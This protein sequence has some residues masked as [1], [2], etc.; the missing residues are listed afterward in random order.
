MAAENFTADDLAHCTPVPDAPLK[1]PLYYLSPAQSEIVRKKGL[2]AAVEAAGGLTQRADGNLGCYLFHRDVAAAL[3]FNLDGIEMAKERFGAYVW[4][5]E[6]ENVHSTWNFREPGFDFAGL[7]FSGPEQLFQLHK[8]GPPTSE[9]FQVHA[10]AFA[11]ATAEMAFALGREVRPFPEGWDDMRDDV[12][13]AVLRAK[14]AH[15]GLRHLLLTTYPHPLVSVKPDRYWGAGIDGQGRNRLG[16]LLV[17]LRDELHGGGH[18][19]PSSQTVCAV[20]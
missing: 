3:G 11:G 6:F 9:A 13:R 16:E 1:E 19:T 5:T 10:P 12:M 20:Q 17:E 18:P 8:Y 4:C 2:T 14:F 15:P 7:H